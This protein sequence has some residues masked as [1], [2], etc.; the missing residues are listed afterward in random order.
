M[1][2]LIK[3]AA[4][5]AL[6][7]VAGCQTAPPETPLEEL[8]DQGARA[9]LAAQRCE[10]YTSLRGDRKL[11]NAS[12][13]IYAK[14]REMGADQSDIDAARLRARQQAGIRDTLIGNEATCDELSILPPGY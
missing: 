14:A 9:E 13:T 5:A 2:K 11:K 12:E 4:F 10:S 3:A 7:T 8:L 6:V 1:V